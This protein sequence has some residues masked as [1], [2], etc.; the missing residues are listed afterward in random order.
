MA[1][2]ERRKQAT[3]GRVGVSALS[4]NVAAGMISA[5]GQSADDMEPCANIDSV[6]PL[7]ETDRDSSAAA[8]APPA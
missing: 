7:K 3:K 1:P 5:F 8:V 2:R 4:P 6:S